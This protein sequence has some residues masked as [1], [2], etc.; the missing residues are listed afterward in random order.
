MRVHPCKS[1]QKNKFWFGLAWIILLIADKH[2]IDH[3]RHKEP[4]K[5]VNIHH[6]KQK[7]CMQRGGGWGG[8]LM[9]IV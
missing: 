9:K 7:C 2:C 1:G 6:Y 3:E 5:I 8:V 4:S